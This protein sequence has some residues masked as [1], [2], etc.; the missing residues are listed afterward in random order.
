MIEE[1][2][3]TEAG[4]IGYSQYRENVIPIASINGQKSKSAASNVPDNG[5]GRK[6]IERVPRQKTVSVQVPSFPDISP[7]TLNME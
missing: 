2:A 5:T 3:L 4:R 6:P 1:L 7:N